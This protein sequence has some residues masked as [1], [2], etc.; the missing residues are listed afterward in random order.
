MG[1]YA[2]DYFRREVKSKFGFDPGSNDKPAVK[3]GSNKTI[4]PKCQ[5]RVVH[6]TKEPA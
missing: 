4:C 3:H 6:N 1:E 5:K 2:D